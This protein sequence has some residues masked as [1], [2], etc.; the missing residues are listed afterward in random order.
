[1]VN[2]GTLKLAAID[3]GSN[4]VRLYIARPLHED[5]ANTDF[6]PVEFTRLPLRLGDDVFK[7]KEIGKKKGDLLVKALQA[8]SL[9]MEIYNVDEMRACGTS[10]MRDA[11]NGEKL[12]KDIKRLTGIRIDIISGKE[13]SRLIQGCVLDWLPG[14]NS[15]LHVDVGGGSTEIAYIRHGKIKKYESFNIGTVR[16]KEGKVKESEI[17]KMKTWLEDLVLPIDEPVKA[18][19]TGGNIVKLLELSGCKSNEPLNLKHLSATNAYVQSL[20]IHDLV[21]ELKLNP[22]R[23][24]VI[25]FAGNIYTDIM[26]ACGIHE[27][28]APNIGLKDGI[29]RDLWKKHF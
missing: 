29:I 1:M 17:S 20:S 23:A 10:A 5:L 25:G 7:T 26:Q 18:V 12:V 13:E 11:L 27:I 24:E 16:L 6:K 22:D 21:Y 14:K 15:F 8:F 4:A 19:G 3:I 2:F 28:L 9:L